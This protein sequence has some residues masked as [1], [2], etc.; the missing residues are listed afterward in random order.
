[1]IER[2]VAWLNGFRRLNR[3]YEYE[4]DHF[5]AFAGMAGPDNYQL[6]HGRAP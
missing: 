2:T 1:M 6:F 5:A 3:R 4:A